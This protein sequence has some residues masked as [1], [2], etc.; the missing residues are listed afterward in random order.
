M[1]QQAA[2][3]HYPEGN[4]SLKL[5]L[6]ATGDPDNALQDKLAKEMGFGSQSGIGEHIYMMVTCHPDISYAVV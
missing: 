6:L 5:S 4:C 2:Q 3:P 1:Y